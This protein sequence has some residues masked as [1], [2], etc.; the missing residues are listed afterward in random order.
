MKALIL[1][2]AV[3]AISCSKPEI[4]PNNGVKIYPQA[5]VIDARYWHVIITSEKTVTSSGT[6]TLEWDVYSEGNDFM[7]HRS[8]TVP[9]SFEGNQN[10]GFIKT[11]VQGATTMKARNEKIVSITGSVVFTY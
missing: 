7:Y 9:Y 4:K 3:A 11:S 2:L 10:T 8:A 5:K 6:I 1:I